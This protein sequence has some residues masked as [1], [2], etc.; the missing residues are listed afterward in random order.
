M[1]ILEIYY[2]V[3]AHN[4]QQIYFQILFTYHIRNQPL[5]N[6]CRR[7]TQNFLWGV[8][9][10]VVIIISI[11]TTYYIFKLDRNLRLYIILDVFSGVLESNKVKYH[12]WLKERNIIQTLLYS[13]TQRGVQKRP[14]HPYSDVPVKS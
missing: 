9:Y 8:K 10:L 12:I 3:Y 2:I 6:H 1:T 4:L 7:H 13:L 11:G 14:K 5:D